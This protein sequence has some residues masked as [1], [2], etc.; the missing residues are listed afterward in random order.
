MY[1]LVTHLHVTFK[2]NKSECPLVDRDHFFHGDR[3]KFM[4]KY[5][6]TNVS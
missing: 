5:L 1:G 2:S 6:K 3:M 4:D